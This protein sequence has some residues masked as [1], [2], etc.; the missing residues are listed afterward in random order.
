[1]E[2]KDQQVIH[3]SPLQNGEKKFR[4]FPT[5]IE[6]VFLQN[7]H[8]IPCFRLFLIIKTDLENKVIESIEANN[9]RDHTHTADKVLTKNNR[10][11]HQ[12]CGGNWFTSQVNA[13]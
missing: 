10:I 4:F 7:L 3:I 5:F 6:L 9:T 1:M 13:L 11:L 12:S 8:P 2:S